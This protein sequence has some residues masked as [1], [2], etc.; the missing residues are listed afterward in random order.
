V[1]VLVIE[2]RAK[3]IEYEDEY[4][5]EYDN[6]AAFTVQKRDKRF[7]FYGGRCRMPVSGCRIGKALCS[8]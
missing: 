2:Q 6:E 3:S 4:E 5:Y 7:E 8:V 1:V